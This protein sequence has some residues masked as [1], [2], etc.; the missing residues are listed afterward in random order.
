MAY[1]TIEEFYE[2]SDLDD[3]QID[4]Q[5]VEK[6]IE[7]AYGQI[8]NLSNT[9]FAS[10]LADCSTISETLDPVPFTTDKS[11]SYIVFNKYPVAQL[12]TFALSGTS[13]ATSN[14]IVYSDRI[15]ISPDATTISDFGTKAQSIAVTYKYGV[16]DG[17]KFQAAKELNILLAILGF[18][19]TPK[20]RNVYMDNFRGLE[21]NANNSRPTDVVQTFAE[22][23][24]QRVEELKKEIGRADLLF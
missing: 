2:Y 17:A 5:L 11:N 4:S 14:F 6:Y 8:N 1:C 19:A 22:D 16:N 18:I 23:I 9:F 15:R 24:K 12:S 13:Y 10:T 21:I 3:S 7:R 20:G